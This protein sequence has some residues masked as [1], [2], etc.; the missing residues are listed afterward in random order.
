V[1]Y[2]LLLPL[3]LPPLEPPVLEPEPLEPVPAPLD[4]LEPVPLDVLPPEEPEEPE[5]LGE[6]PAELPGVAL[7]EPLAVL[8]LLI[9]LPLE[10]PVPLPPLAVLWSLVAPLEP[11]FGVVSELRWQPAASATA[12][13]T[14]ATNTR[15][16]NDFISILLLI[17]IMDVQRPCMFVPKS[18]YRTGNT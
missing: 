8:P 1:C 2:W 3:L 9:P 13:D 5:P 17:K 10:L 6:A 18:H 4:P 7:G 16:C 12:Q 15:F 11:D 14:A